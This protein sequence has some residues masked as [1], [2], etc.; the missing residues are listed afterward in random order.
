[1]S[2]LVLGTVKLSVVFF[3]RRVF[4]GSHFDVYSKAMIALILLWTTAF[5]FT[6]LF[7]CRTDFKYLWSTLHD[8]LTHC[9]D[10]V[11]YQKAMIISDVITDA[12]IIVMPL[13]VV[14]ICQLLSVGERK[15]DY[16]RCCA[17]KC[18][19]QRRLP[20]VESSCWVLCEWIMVTQDTF[21][22]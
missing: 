12:L 15:A 14:S 20:S 19:A 8:L 13:P 16:A 17:F 2:V 6:V 9:S 3:Y 10:D 21:N 4:R 11:L 5:F 22:C 1:M 7:E 18:Q